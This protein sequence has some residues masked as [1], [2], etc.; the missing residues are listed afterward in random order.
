MTFEQLTQFNID[1]LKWAKAQ[2]EPNERIWPEER[3][4][5]NEA[6]LY[7]IEKFNYRKVENKQEKWVVYIITI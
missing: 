6:D 3:R 7:Y 5:I 1:W 2:L 4:Y